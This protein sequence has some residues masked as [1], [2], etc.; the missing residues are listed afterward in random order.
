MP[1]YIEIKGEKNPEKLQLYER[2]PNMMFGE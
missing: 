2:F 1:E